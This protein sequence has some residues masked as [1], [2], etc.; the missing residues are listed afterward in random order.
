MNPEE[1]T[2]LDEPI[3]EPAPLKKGYSNSLIGILMIV[4]LLLIVAGLQ[5]GRYIST[6]SS[7]R[8]LQDPNIVPP[9]P[10]P[11]PQPT[12]D[13]CRTPTPSY[14]PVTK[15]IVSPTGPIIIY[16]ITPEPSPSP[17]PRNVIAPITQKQAP[18]IPT[19]P[20]N[21][22]TPTPSTSPCP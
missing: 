21:P 14:I 6:A 11:T 8:E 5:I 3:V 9:S 13:P 17:T 16:P 1:I 12:V 4:L 18:G 15:T 19:W 22:P 7:A 20:T 2:P 10:S